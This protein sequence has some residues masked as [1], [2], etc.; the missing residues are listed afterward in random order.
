[1]AEDFPFDVLDT[2]GFVNGRDYL[3]CFDF[4]PDM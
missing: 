1:M 2:A 4:L 3:N